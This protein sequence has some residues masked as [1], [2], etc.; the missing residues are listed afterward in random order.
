MLSTFKITRTVYPFYSLKSLFQT[1][2]N[3]LY[4]HFT[5]DTADNPAFNDDDSENGVPKDKINV[6]SNGDVMPESER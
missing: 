3:G 6:S 1:F 5:I 4:S 2:F